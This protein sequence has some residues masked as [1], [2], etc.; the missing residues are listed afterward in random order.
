MTVADRVSRRISLRYLSSGVV[1]SDP[2][3]DLEDLLAELFFHFDYFRVEF[4]V[5]VSDADGCKLAE[6]AGMESDGTMTAAYL[7]EDGTH[8]DAKLY[9]LLRPQFP[10]QGYG[11]VPFARGVIAVLGSRNAVRQVAFLHDDTRS[12]DRYLMECAEFAGLLD[13]EGYIRNP[14]HRFDMPYAVP[15][16]VEH[17]CQQIREYLEHRRSVFDVAVQWPDKA[18]AFQKAV[19]DVLRQI[20]YGRNW[21]YEEVAEHLPDRGPAR[22]LARAVGAACAANPVP[23]IIPCHRVIGKDQKLVGFS[24]GVDIKEYLLEHEWII[25]EGEEK[26]LEGTEPTHD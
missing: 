20:G 25:P 19:W 14:G 16:E 18:T 11:F 17:A 13:E 3:H 12:D 24:G 7:R 8:E 22:N 5:P 1:G 9:Y 23:L 15:E 26:Q 6:Q 10:S 2:V 21:S 4:P